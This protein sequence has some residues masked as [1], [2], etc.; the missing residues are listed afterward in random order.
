MWIYILNIW[1]DELNLVDDKKYKTKE[2]YIYY[3]VLSIF[4]VLMSLV[5]SIS[6]V[7]MNCHTLQQVSI[8]G[9]IGIVSSYG[10]YKLRYYLNI[11]NDDKIL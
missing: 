5:V 6:R 3:I 8:G 4:L 11:K 10:F 2:Q 1:E 7:E 9:L